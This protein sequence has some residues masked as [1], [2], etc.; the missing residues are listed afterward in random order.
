MGPPHKV[1]GIICVYIKTRLDFSLNM[2]RAF[3]FT[4][5]IKTDLF[6]YFSVQGMELMNNNVVKKECGD[7]V[8][9]GG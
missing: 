6:I 9:G 8:N 3:F 2:R 1:E 5:E 7:R 4:F